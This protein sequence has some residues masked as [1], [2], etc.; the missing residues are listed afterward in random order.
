MDIKHKTK[1]EALA[2][3]ITR[4]EDQ[5]AYCKQTNCPTTYYDNLIAG[6]RAEMKEIREEIDEA[7]WYAQHQLDLQDLADWNKRYAR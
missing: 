5:I 4:Y 1:L 6:V 2:I 3:Q 7:E